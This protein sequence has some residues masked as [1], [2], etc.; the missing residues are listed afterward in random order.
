MSQ[1]HIYN[2]RKK[3]SCDADSRTQLFAVEETLIAIIIITIIYN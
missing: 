3:Y 2:N 1:N